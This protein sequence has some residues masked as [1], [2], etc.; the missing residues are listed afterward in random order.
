MEGLLGRLQLVL[1]IAFLLLVLSSDVEVNPGPVCFLCSV[2][3][4]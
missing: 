3:A 2:G 4:C 1:W